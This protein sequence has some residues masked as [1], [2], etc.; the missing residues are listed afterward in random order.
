MDIGLSY[1]AWWILP[2][3]LIA[4]LVSYWLYRKSGETEDWP[5]WQ[6]PSLFSLRFV[7][8]FALCFL[9]LDPVLK[10]LSTRFEKPSIIFLEDVSESVDFLEDSVYLNETWPTEKQ[11]IIE[12]LSE[13]YQVNEHQFANGLIEDSTGGL[14]LTNFSSTLKELGVRYGGSNVG[15]LIVASDGQVN[16][17]QDPVYAAYDLSSPVYTLGFGSNASPKDLK[18]DA[19]ENNSVVYLGNDFPVKVNFSASNAKGE[20]IRLSLFENNRLLSSS[21]HE[22]EGEL[23]SFQKEFSV[24]AKQSGLKRLRVEIESIEGEWSLQNNVK[25]S[26]VE[27]L[28]GRQK[29]LIL[30]RSYHP[31]VAAVKNALSASDNYECDAFTWESVRDKNLK[32]LSA[33]YNLIV[34][35]ELPSADAS[36]MTFLE[37]L[38]NEG[39][40]I[41]FIAGLRSD[42]AKLNALKTGVNIGTNRFKSNEAGPVLNKSFS[43]FS[44]DFDERWLEECPPLVSPFGAY[45]ESAGTE[46]LFGQRVGNLST[47]QAL[48]FFN[49][50][51]VRKLAVLLGEGIWRWRLYD[52]QKTGG[53]EN[54]NQLIR[55]TV[56]FLASREEKKRFRL[57]VNRTYSDIQ[58]IQLSAEL[59]NQSY[60][61]SFESEISFLL[62]NEEGAEFP[63][64]FQK[65]DQNYQLSLGN[66][67]PGLYTYSAKTQLSGQSFET[68]GEFVVQEVSLERSLVKADH[69]LLQR[70]SKE[71][72]GDFTEVRNSAKIVD[73]ILNSENIQEIGHTDERF[74][75]LLDF[76]WIFFIL[77]GLLSIEWFLRKFNGSI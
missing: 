75:K 72:G 37:D 48:L 39:Y 16:R 10:Y 35:H 17:G 40:P 55:K 34:A 49:V 22:V 32:D 4:F 59:Y 58:E 47:G 43:L 54:F 73:S 51:D 53:H 50:S 77:L 61:R 60:E 28:D 56:R 57:N 30:S 7:L 42:L 2:S 6:R 66:L 74:K 46:V 41:W 65:T 15:A 23:A 18:I 20:Q 69:N 64:S 1:S 71:T 31:D 21:L 52:Y 38:S 24:S 14:K 29:V 36:S 45:N 76:Q 70:W 3:A 44:T 26:F 27:V 11:A 9:L 63:F 68:S 62:V 67:E 8:I 12:R 33:S 5:K 19:L 25:E 13:K